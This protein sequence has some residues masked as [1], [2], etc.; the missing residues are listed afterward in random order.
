MEWTPL[1]DGAVVKRH[2]AADERF[3][4]AGSGMELCV[5]PVAGPVEAGAVLA[6][7]F[8]RRI[9]AAEMPALVMPGHF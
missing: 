7:A 5:L 4:F 6:L 8:L 1:R 9:P 2:Q 3:R